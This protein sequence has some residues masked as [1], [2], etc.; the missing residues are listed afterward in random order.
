VKMVCKINKN[1]LQICIAKL[2][3]NS[4]VIYLNIQILDNEKTHLRKEI[5]KY[6]NLVPDSTYGIFAISAVS[7][8][9]FI[10]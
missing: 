1:L 6:D 9:N 2:Y 7:V 10:C 5:E 3:C 8:I 4:K